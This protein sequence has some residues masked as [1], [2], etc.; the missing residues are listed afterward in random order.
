MPSRT[1]VP[2]QRWFVAV[3]LL[4]LILVR[5]PIGE[6][7]AQPKAPAADRWDAVRALIRQTMAETNLPSISVA[8]SKGGRI[9]WEESFGWADASRR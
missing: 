3:A 8:A 6:T 5:V 2:R 1:H 9:V 4:A 7:M